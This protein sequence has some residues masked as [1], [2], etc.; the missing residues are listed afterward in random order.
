MSFLLISPTEPEQIRQLGKTSL[1]PEKYGVDI[2]IIERGLYGIQRK[3]FPT[4]L[5]ASLYDGRFQK[6]IID[7]RR[8]KFSILLLEGEAKWTA[9]GQLLDKYAK[10]S[11]KQLYGIIWSLQLYGIFTY[12]TSNIQNTIQYLKM[13]YEWVNKEKHN[14]LRRRPKPKST[15]FIPTKE[16]KQIHFLQGIDGIGVDIAKNIIDHFGKIPLEWRNNGKKLTENDFMEIPRVGAETA[17]RLLK[18]FTA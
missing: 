10:L 5:V 2:L 15:M 13:F 9:D 12:W 8:L 3:V 11:I 6:Q 7:M 16:E 18:F 4:D 14:S 17:K 1:T